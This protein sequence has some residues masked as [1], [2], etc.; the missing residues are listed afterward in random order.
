MNTLQKMELLRQNI[1]NSGRL[2]VAFSGGVDSTFLLKTA[3]D[4]LGEGAIAITVKS[5]A[6]PKRETA[7]TE[8]F[9]KKEHIFQV[10]CDFK[11]LEIEEFAQNHTDR[12]YY[13]KRKLFQKITGIAREQGIVH[14]A[15]GSNTDDLADYR[16]GLKA[17]EELG[18]LSPLKEAGLCK[19]DIRLLSKELGLSTWEK[20]S[21]ACLASRFVY[22]ETITAEKLHMVEQAENFLTGLGFLQIRVR[23]HG[24]MARIE[25]LP[26]DFERFFQGK[27]R[28]AVD[29]TLKEIGFSYVSLDLQGYRTGSMNEIIKK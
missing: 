9:C 27:N 16:P 29:Q 17:V 14:V 8:E 13:C 5:D 22:G 21:C 24:D 11:P 18:I 3:K 20:P 1:K 25:A 19:S 4:V 15:E 23:I 6:F 26:E 12:C 7:E 10:I 2:A 28:Q